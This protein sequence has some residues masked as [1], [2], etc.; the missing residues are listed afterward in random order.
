VLYLISQ[1]TS[2]RGGANRLVS[3][4][5]GLLEE[6]IEHGLVTQERDEQTGALKN[7]VVPC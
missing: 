7:S 1:L 5:P 4:A 3:E 2:G 6:A